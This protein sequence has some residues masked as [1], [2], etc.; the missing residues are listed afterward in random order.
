M[1]VLDFPVSVR[2]GDKHK[3]CPLR[4]LIKMQWDRQNMITASS[5]KNAM[6]SV[7]INE[8]Y[9]A[10]LLNRDKKYIEEYL[11]KMQHKPICR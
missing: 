5:L 7:K 11:S 1:D 10:V 4:T 8:K 3:H 2:E 6:T 9:Q